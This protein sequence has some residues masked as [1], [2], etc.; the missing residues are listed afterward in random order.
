MFVLLY[1]VC[2]TDQ[3]AMQYVVPHAVRALKARSLRLAD[4]PEQRELGE[5]AEGERGVPR[6]VR[7]PSEIVDK[8][9]AALEP[10]IGQHHRI[11]SAGQHPTSTGAKQS[12]AH[13]A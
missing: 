11:A 10:C 8:G 1:G 4:H 12:T 7:G 3:S 5:R 2:S 6:V 13:G 9:H